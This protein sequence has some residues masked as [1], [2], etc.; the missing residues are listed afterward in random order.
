[1]TLTEYTPSPEPLLMTAAQ[2]AERLGVSLTTVRRATRAG[3]LPCRRI[4]EWGIRYTLADLEG[5][6]EAIATRR[7]RPS[8]G[9]SP[10][11]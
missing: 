10:A 4:G 3:H 2:A 11:G 6:V 1:M 5:W 9:R 8:A 7:H